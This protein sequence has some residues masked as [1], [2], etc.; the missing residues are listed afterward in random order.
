MTGKLLVFGLALAGGLMAEEKKEEGKWVSLFNGKDLTGWT[1]KIQ[2]QELGVNWRDTFRVEDGVLKVVYDEY[3]QWGPYYGHLFYQ[4]EYSH[5]RLRV[6]YRFVGEQVKGGEG[7]AKRNNGLMLHGQSAASMELNKDYPDS[8]EVQLLGGLDDGRERTTLNL[9][10]P[11]T[12]VVMDD[13]VQKQHCINSKSKTYHGDQWVT[14]EVLVEGGKSF[15]HLIDGEVVM[16]YQAP[17]LDDGTILEKGTISIQS[18][19]HPTEFRKIEIMNLAE[20]K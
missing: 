4:T 6:E 16:T 2:G 5:Y 20:E 18:E 1:P 11:G 9:C 19:S 3:D 17:Q 15:T 12:Q 7:W 13:Q 14:V 8:I 10:S